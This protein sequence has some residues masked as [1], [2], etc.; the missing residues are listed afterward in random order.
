MKIFLLVCEAGSRSD[1]QAFVNRLDDGARMYAFGE[2][3]RFIRSG[4][5]VATLTDRFMQVAGPALFFLTEV[6][7]A[8][9][10]GRMV[11]PFWDFL[12]VEPLAS[13]A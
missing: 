10:K 1:L 5:D 11:G 13:A 8:D 4:L 12:E 7:E 9:Y 6:G 2:Q 3:A